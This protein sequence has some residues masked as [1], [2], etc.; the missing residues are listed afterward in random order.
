MQR[1]KKGDTV[2]VIAGKDKGEQ[3]EV[4]RVLPKTNR[5]IVNGVNQVKRHQKARPGPGGQT[6]PAQIIEKDAPLDLSNVM[7]VCTKC[8]KPT[9]VGY[10][11]RDDG[12][13]TRTC[14][15]CDADI[16]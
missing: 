12:F 16:D 3:G 1:I 8:N 14:K 7:I 6:I 10:R 11:V 2:L 4:L 5:V 13:K 9:R 15:K